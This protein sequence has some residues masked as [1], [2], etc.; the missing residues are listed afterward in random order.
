[1]VGGPKYHGT[2]FLLPS[3][4]ERIARKV[5]RICKTIAD[6]KTG[7]ATATIAAGDWPTYNYMLRDKDNTMLNETTTFTAWYAQVAQLLGLT[8]I[9]QLHSDSDR[10]SDTDLR[11]GR[12]PL[13]F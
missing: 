11:P 3:E 5:Q 2:D 9:D 4:H 8:L 10:L 12:A 13:L 6:L 7:K 1:M